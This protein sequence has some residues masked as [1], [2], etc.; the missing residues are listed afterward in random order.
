MSSSFP[1]EANEA[2]VVEQARSVVDDHD[3]AP[4]TRPSVASDEA[5]EADVLEQGA[6][7]VEDDER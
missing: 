5:S 1:D 6:E 2:D 7:L 4:P 3:D